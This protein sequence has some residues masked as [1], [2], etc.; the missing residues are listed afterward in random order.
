LRRH[1]DRL[2]RA[3]INFEKGVKL[4]TDNKGIKLFIR[5]KGYINRLI[6]QSALDNKKMIKVKYVYQS[7]I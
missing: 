4:S 6:N 5:S 2:I 3:C 1:S 7:L